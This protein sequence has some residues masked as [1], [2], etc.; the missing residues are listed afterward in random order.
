MKDFIITFGN[1]KTS[2]TKNEVQSWF[3]P[4]AIPNTPLKQPQMSM[5]KSSKLMDYINSM[6]SNQ[7]NYI[8]DTIE[9][10]KLDFYN[11]HDVIKEAEQLDREG[12]FPQNYRD[13]I[14]KTFHGIDEKAFYLFKYA[15]E[16][17]RRYTYERIEW[18]HD[19][20]DFLPI[21]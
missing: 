19:F 8:L 5:I 12:R 1:N 10:E 16:K 18:Y 21:Q 2:F 11:V 4:S 20:N 9:N 7:V 13:F 15:Y 3:E 14:V 17:D 6:I